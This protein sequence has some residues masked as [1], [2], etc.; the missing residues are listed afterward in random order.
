MSELSLA[1]RLRIG[2][3]ARWNIVRV[4]KQQ[5]V[6]EHSAMVQWIALHLA[7]ELGLDAEQQRDVCIW[8]MWHD[9]PE[10]HTG[11]IIT[12]MKKHF[13][14]PLKEVEYQVSNEYA[15]LDGYTADELQFVVKAAELI[16]AIRFL[17]IESMDLHGKRVQ[18][19]MKA[20]LTT[21][22]QKLDHTTEG[23]AMG[24]ITWHEAIYRTYQEAMRDVPNDDGPWNEGS[25]G[26][27]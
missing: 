24:G 25:E 11:D 14:E 17:G 7:R 16:E 5:S 10:V 21:L 3:V 19:N 1:Q 13:R 9:L 27:E 12:P 4:A 22:A 6:A 2:H 8:A 18:R 26:N 15:T 23:V 20:K